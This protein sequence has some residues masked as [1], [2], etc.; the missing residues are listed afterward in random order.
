MIAK[1]ISVVEVLLASDCL[2]VLECSVCVCEGSVCVVK[3]WTVPIHAGFTPFGPAA[4]AVPPLSLL[5]LSTLSKFHA[6]F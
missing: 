1:V 6:R 2:I 4:V 5:P 3:Q